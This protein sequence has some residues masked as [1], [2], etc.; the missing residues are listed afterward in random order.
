VS[1]EVKKNLIYNIVTNKNLNLD[2]IKKNKGQR[3]KNKKLM[4]L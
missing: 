4:Y 3:N 1:R 2:N